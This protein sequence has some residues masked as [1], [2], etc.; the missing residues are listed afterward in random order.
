MKLLKGGDSFKDNPLS[1]FLT[2]DLDIPVLSQ[3]VTET[4]APL[5]TWGVRGRRDQ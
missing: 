1:R 4:G 5:C 2:Q 3:L